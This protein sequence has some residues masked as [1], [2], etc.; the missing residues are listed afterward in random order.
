MAGT[1]TVAPQY[2][3]LLLQRPDGLRSSYTA[4]RLPSHVGLLYALVR[5]ERLIGHRFGIVA[6]PGVLKPDFQGQAVFV[7]RRRCQT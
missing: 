6:H 4:Y 5:L 1:V 2:F 7:R 3:H